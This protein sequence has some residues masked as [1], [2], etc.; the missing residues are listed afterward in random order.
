MM[1]L[2]PC[3]MSVCAVPG[4]EGLKSSCCVAFT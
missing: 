1:K 2:V 3:R 4:A